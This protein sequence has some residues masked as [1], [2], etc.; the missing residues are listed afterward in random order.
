MD[1]MYT[2]ARDLLRG[3]KRKVFNNEQATF[4]KQTTDNLK[5]S[6]D[7]MMVHIF[8]NKAYKLQKWY[9]CCM[10]HKPRHVSVSKWIARVIKLNNYLTEFSMPPGVE[11]MKMDQGEILEVLENGIP[12][13]WKFQMD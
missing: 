7:V 3:D 5:Q 2:L 9:I 8:P 4:K 12:T 13:L 10:M 1:T 11:S 6:L